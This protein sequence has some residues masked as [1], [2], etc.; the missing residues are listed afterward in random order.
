MVDST[1]SLDLITTRIILYERPLI[2]VKLQVIVTEEAILILGVKEELIELQRKMDQIRHFLIDA[3][4]RSIKE[5]A[6]N[7]WLGQL[8]DAMYDADDIIDMARFKGNKLLSDLDSTLSSKQ[9]KCSWLSLSSCFSNLWTRHEIAVKIRSLNKRI[10]GIS[11]DNVFLSLA[12]SESNARG[13]QSTTRKSSFLVEPNLVGK[14]IIY[15][16][17]KVVELV[18]ANKENKSYKAAIVG[19]GGVSKTTLA[20]KIYN[21]QKIKGTFEKQEWLCVSKDYSEVALLKEVL[22]YI[23]IHQRQGESVGELQSILA[24]SIKDKSFFLVLDDVW[25]S[26]TWTELLRTPLQFASAGIIL[27]TTRHDIVAM[28]IGVDYTHRVDLMSVDVGWELL[29]KSMNIKEEK[30]VQNLR[31][32][33]IEIVQKCGG[34]PLGIKLIARVSLS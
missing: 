7:N 15:A 21:D 24:S 20:Q 25:Q 4:G 9:N 32:V 29:W 5:S 19:T 33:G 34:L 13:S 10:E 28:E 14:E 23:G 1:T 31:G 2:Q 11:K 17:R 30:E 22:R 3:E 6:V 27:V 26:D 12:N 16:C 18:L 8:R